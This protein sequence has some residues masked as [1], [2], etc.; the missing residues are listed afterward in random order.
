MAKS[1]QEKFVTL[2]AG[3][4]KVVVGSVPLEKIVHRRKNYRKMNKHQKETLQASVNKFGFQ[5]LITVVKNEDGTYGIVDGHH[6]V[7]EL[8]ARGS[9]RI[10]VVLLP[11]GTSKL[12]ADLGMLS[13][14]VSAEII[15]AEFASFVKELMDA[16]TDAD[17]LR[18]HATISEG[19]MDTLKEALN[20][21][22]GDAPDMEDLPSSVGGEKVAK[23]RKAPNVKVVLL[24]S[25]DADG[26]PIPSF[27]VTHKDTVLDKE[28]RD[29]LEGEG[30]EVEEIEPVWF[31]NGPNLL[32][33]LA[34]SSDEDE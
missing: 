29:V 25:K 20:E 6:R 17:E 24:I 30:F 34:A 4:N 28:V 21:P 22:S 5:D 13:F 19:F 2:D 31:D 3:I 27:C 12:D 8:A 16:G 1:D 23:P 32:E 11:E 26:N 33:I 7:E 15:D 14:N 9:D 18:K 10:P